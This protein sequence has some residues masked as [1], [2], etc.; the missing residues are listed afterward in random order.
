[1]A[2]TW[3]AI[4]GR[5]S[6]SDQ[7]RMGEGSLPARNAM[8]SV[9]ANVI[10]TR[11]TPLSA[12][13]QSPTLLTTTTRN[14]A[15]QKVSLEM[16]V[17]AAPGSVVLAGT[18]F[19]AQRERRQGAPLLSQLVN[20]GQEDAVLSIVRGD[21]AAGSGYGEAHHGAHVAVVPQ[22]ILQLVVDRIGEPDAADGVVIGI[23]DS[24]VIL[25]RIAEANLGRDSRGD[26]A[27]GTPLHRPALDVERDE[28]AG[29]DVVGKLLR[30]RLNGVDF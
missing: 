2:S 7:A 18:V 28:P 22:V 10:L 4:A 9:M 30:R 27:L 16:R 12:S 1:M 26:D 23:T 8:M 15:I 5:A 13:I 11:G 17:A 21:P 29:V 6:L 14:A 20:D 3:K 24:P 25:V 19:T